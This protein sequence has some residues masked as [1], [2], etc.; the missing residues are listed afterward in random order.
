MTKLYT[1]TEAAAAIQPHLD[2][3]AEGWLADT[4]RTK[5]RGII[6]RVSPPLPLRREGRIYYRS[7]DIAR[8]IAELKAL[9]LPKHRATA[10]AVV[11]CI[12]ATPS[13]GIA[14]GKVAI[15]IDGTA[16]AMNPA[17]ARRFVQDLAVACVL[18]ERAA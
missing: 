13:V 11:P 3:D 17:D 18:A 5:R 9:N 10:P 4:R 12:N 7:D 14:G 2:I 15:E 8:V 1:P 16:I 6:D